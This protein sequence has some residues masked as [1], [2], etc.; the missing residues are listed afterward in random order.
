MCRNV[1][2]AGHCV[3]N[4][5]VPIGDGIGKADCPEERRAAHLQACN[6][7]DG[8]RKILICSGPENASE[9]LFPYYS[10]HSP[11]KQ[12]ALRHYGQR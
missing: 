10:G 2:S 6:G 9:Q 8:F 12:E 4:F 1:N 3:C 7:A 11:L 5:T